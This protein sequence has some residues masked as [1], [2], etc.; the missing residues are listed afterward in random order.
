LILEIKILFDKDLLC[1]YCKNKDTYLKS[2]TLKNIICVLEEFMERHQFNKY[3]HDLKPYI[4]DRW[5]KLTE[6]D[7]NQID[8]RFDIFSSKLQNKYKISKNHMEEQF[9]NWKPNVRFEAE[10]AFKSKKIQIA[11]EQEVNIRKW[12]VGAAV[13]FILLIG[14]LGVTQNYTTTDSK[15]DL[16]ASY[17]NI[18]AM[19]NPSF[20]PTADE[21]ITENIRKVLYSNALLLVDLEGLKIENS[22][23]V[24]TVHGTVK[25]EDEKNLVKDQVEMIP[26]VVKVINNIKIRN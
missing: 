8:A 15:S 5:S 26:G 3:Y 1:Y 16:Y 13:S 11:K 2:N 9:H 12:L 21:T 7:M 19:A 17:E 23:G 4:I 14:I 24:V 18:I 22:E 25:N 6:E 10:D 20:G